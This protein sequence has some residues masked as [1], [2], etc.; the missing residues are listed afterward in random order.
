MKARK[1]I[2][3]KLLHEEQMCFFGN[4][5]WNL[6][7]HQERRM[8]VIFL[9]V[10]AGLI[11]NVY[12]KTKCSPGEG[13]DHVFLGEDPHE[14]GCLAASSPRNC[15]FKSDKKSPWRFPDASIE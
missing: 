3:E 15:C 4:I 8:S 2:R 5:N 9:Y 14:V 12:F 10:G 1:Y 11:F 6:T 7:E 13:D